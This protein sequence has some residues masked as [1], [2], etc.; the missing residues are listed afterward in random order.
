MAPGTPLVNNDS[1]IVGKFVQILD[2][3]RSDW[4]KT[5]KIDTYDAAT[6]RIGVAS[7]FD[8]VM[9]ISTPY[10]ILGDSGTP[11]LVP[12]QT[13]FWADYP[14]FFP[15][16]A[17]GNFTI[18][19]ARGTSREIDLNINSC[20][21]SFGVNYGFFDIGTTSPNIADNYYAGDSLEL[22]VTKIAL[23]SVGS[24][25]TLEGGFYCEFGYEE[26]ALTQEESGVSNYLGNTYPPRYFGSTESTV[27]YSSI[28]DPLNLNN[29]LYNKI[30]GELILPVA[31][32]K[33]VAFRSVTTLD[34]SA[35]SNFTDPSLGAVTEILIF[36][37]NFIDKRF[38]DASLGGDLQ[39]QA[40]VGTV[41]HLLSLTIKKV[42]PGVGAGC[43]V[44]VSPQID[45]ATYSNILAGAVVTVK[46]PMRSDDHEALLKE[47]VYVGLKQALTTSKVENRQYV[48]LN[49]SGGAL[50]YI[51]CADIAPVSTALIGRQVKITDYT[52]ASPAAAGDVRTIVAI[53]GTA[54]DRLRVDSNFGVAIALN[55]TFEILPSKNPLYGFPRGSHSDVGGVYTPV[56]HDGVPG[57]ATPMLFGAPAYPTGNSST[58]RFPAGREYGIV[59]EYVKFSKRVNNILTLSNPYYFKYDHPSGSRVTFG[60]GEKFT[61]GDGTDHR[62]Y[63]FS[64]GYLALL[65][66]DA[67]GFKNLFTAA[68]IECKTE[69]TELGP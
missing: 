20:V 11:V 49:S 51:T 10:R 62:P 67:A 29:G 34:V 27:S 24:L 15:D 31:T 7:N 5:F 8:S 22:K 1:R 43:L 50:N 35:A 66:S 33:T 9:L 32:T 38:E 6:R 23:P 52:G 56:A 28:S 44:L 12:G 18:T 64:S 45:F 4:R 30:A 46:A 2:N 63:V 16:P 60:T 53:E 59:E 19:L 55:T 36:G 68:G 47:S 25:P 42:L 14:E 69:E 41:P 17:Q 54:F 58:N 21:N 26:E 39:I 40:M 57:S 3:Q 48:N 65:F 13:S 37:D 61:A